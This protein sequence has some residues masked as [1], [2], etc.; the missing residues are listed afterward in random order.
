MPGPRK[1]KKQKEP[2]DSEFSDVE[3]IEDEGPPSIDPYAV[4]GLDTEATADDVKKAYRKLALKHH[5]DKVAESDKADAHRKFQEIAFAYAVLSDEQ[6]RKRYDL[7]GSTAEVVEGDADF[8][9]HD[10]YRAMFDD[11]VT[12][13]NIKRVTIDYKG[14]AEERRDLSKAYNVFGG[15]LD[16]IYESVMLSDILEDDDRFRSILAEEIEK[17]NLESLPAYERSNTEAARE[18][19]KAA[20]RKRREKFHKKHGTPA[21][22]AKKAKAEQ[23]RKKQ[24]PSSMGDLAAI[25]QSRQ[26]AR[27]NI[28]T[29]ADHIAA[30]YASKPGSKKRASALDDM[31]SE[32]AFQAT[33]EKMNKRLKKDIDAS[34][35]EDGEDIF[36]SDG[37]EE[38]ERP[39]PRKK[40]RLT[41]GRRRTK[42]KA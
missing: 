22:A 36:Q 15:N 17:G 35:E 13:E 11:V 7:T 26:R 20:E 9:W 25:I 3:E 16:A 33:R 1:Q 23:G 14:S 21:E 18:K 42:T 34:A 4:L 8:N 5:P 41:R 28:D 38:D 32:E 6:R 12:E 19:S 29:L 31:P 10:F 30:K 39:K 37:T 27:G 40:G 24:Q 2:K